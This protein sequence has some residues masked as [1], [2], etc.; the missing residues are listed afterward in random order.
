MNIEV[1]LF[2]GL[3]ELEPGSVVRIEL[4]AG[5]RVGDARAALQAHGQARWPDNSL[6]LLR[7]SA[8]ASED[9]LLRDGES[10][11]EDGQLYLLPPVSGG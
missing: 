3:S 4:P 5:A 10:V 6:A 9:S 7:V 11:P 1:R 8:F 2:G